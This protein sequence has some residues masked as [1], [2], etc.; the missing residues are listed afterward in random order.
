M[1]LVPH[2]GGH[3][4]SSIGVSDNHG[5]IIANAAKD[6]IAGLAILLQWRPMRLPGFVRG[7][8]FNFLCWVMFFTLTLHID[9]TGS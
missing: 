6:A 5:Q 7:G 9:Y 3:A 2:L 4:N 8:V 1:L